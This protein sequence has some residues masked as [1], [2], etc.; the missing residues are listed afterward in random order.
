VVTVE[1][2][3][4][5]QVHPREIFSDAIAERIAS[6]ILVHNHP[7]GNTEPSHADIAVTKRLVE[8]G[9]IWG[10]KSMITLSYR[11]IGTRVWRRVRLI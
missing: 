2:L 8:A 4:T 9:E 11:K 5:N 7:S 1:I 10:S 6:T 3:N